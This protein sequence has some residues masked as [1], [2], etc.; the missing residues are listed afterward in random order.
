MEKIK[1]IKDKAGI[2]VLI[3]IATHVTLGEIRLRTTGEN[4]RMIDLLSN[5][6]KLE[7]VKVA[8]TFRFSI[9]RS[10][11]YQNLECFFNFSDFDGVIRGSLKSKVLI[12]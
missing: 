3:E 9:A 6:A 10:S 11:M 5:L 1:N 4:Q 12:A 2:I 8:Q 7:G